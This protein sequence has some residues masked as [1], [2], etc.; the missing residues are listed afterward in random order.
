MQILLVRESYDPAIVARIQAALDSVQMQHESA[1]EGS[2][3]EAAQGAA[4]ANADGAQQQVAPNVKQETAEAAGQQA[5]CDAA[6]EA[7][8]ATVELLQGITNIK[9]N[10]TMDFETEC[11]SRKQPM[12]CVAL[13]VPFAP[14]S[15]PSARADLEVHV[16]ARQRTTTVTPF[17]AACCSDLFNLPDTHDAAYTLTPL[18]NEVAAF[19]LR[20]YF[21][22]EVD[23]AKGDA[24]ESSWLWT[25]SL[26][27]A[28]VTQALGVLLKQQYNVTYTI[29]DS[30]EDGT[31]RTFVLDPNTGPRSGSCAPGEV[32]STMHLSS[33]APSPSPTAEH[34]SCKC[35]ES[36][37]SLQQLWCLQGEFST[38][39]FTKTTSTSS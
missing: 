9:Q 13:C 39:P 12:T 18:G 27:G 1:T 22:E 35:A 38:R 20:K 33:A 11:A 19:R 16:K 8:E 7:D 23:A 3:L 34:G 29:A 30:P 36:I 37:A 17:T 5:P 28:Y 21:A 31:R 10:S 14:Q 24:V 32:Q 4:R 15:A 26:V 2:P 6:R 25:G